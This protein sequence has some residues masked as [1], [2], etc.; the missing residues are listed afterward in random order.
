MSKEKP[1]LERYGSW[2]MFALGMGVCSIAVIWTV[3][4]IIP[5][6]GEPDMI[7]NDCSVELENLLN[8]DDPYYVEP[9][10]CIRKVGV[11]HNWCEAST[12]SAI[13]IQMKVWCHLLNG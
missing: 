12:P 2:I 10:E 9:N 8:S 13:Y 7:S 1:F 4:V 6:I 5:S 11:G 3:Y